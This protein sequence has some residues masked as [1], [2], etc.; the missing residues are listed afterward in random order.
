MAFDPPAKQHS[1]FSPSGS[2][3]LP[4][5]SL[6][7]KSHCRNSIFSIFL[8]SPHQVDMKNVV[9]SSKHFFGYFNTQETHIYK[10]GRDQISRSLNFNY[11]NCKATIFNIYFLTLTMLKECQFSLIIWP[12]GKNVLKNFNGKDQSLSPKILEILDPA[13][14]QSKKLL[15]IFDQKNRY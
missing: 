2:T 10:C 5:L 13:T 6:P 9:K 1:Q 14:G 7:S 8:E 12:R 15:F 3:F 11:Q 4:C